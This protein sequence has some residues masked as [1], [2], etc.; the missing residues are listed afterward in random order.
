MRKGAGLLGRL[1][2]RVALQELVQRG[3][4]AVERIDLIRCCKPGELRGRVL[5]DASQHIDCVVVTISL[6]QSV[7]PSRIPL[8]HLALW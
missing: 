7:A 6:V 3:L 5:A 2:E 4:A 8:I 1:D